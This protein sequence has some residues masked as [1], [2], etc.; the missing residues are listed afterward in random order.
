MSNGLW[1]DLPS[2]ENLRTPATILNEQIAELQRGTN[3]L[4]TGHLSAQQ[5]E[6]AMEQ[7]FYV[8]APALN[9]YAV[10][11]LRIKHGMDLYPCHVWA[12]Q[13]SANAVRAGDEEDFVAILKSILQHEKTRAIIAGLLAQ[14]RSQGT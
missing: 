7:D 3:G 13:I 12:S 5:Q 14:I 10:K 4:L 2:G 1:G 6:D 8:I 9:R 11:I